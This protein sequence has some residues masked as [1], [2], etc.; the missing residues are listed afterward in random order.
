MT[1]SAEATN[2]VTV[3]FEDAALMF[4]LPRDA[5]LEDLAERVAGMATHHLGGPVAIGV[6]LPH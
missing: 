1:R 5:T 4:A 3:V 6:K 2:E